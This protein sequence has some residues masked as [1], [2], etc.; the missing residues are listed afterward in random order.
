MPG[1]L[2]TLRPAAV[3]YTDPEIDLRAL[4]GHSFKIGALP[5]FFDV[6]LGQ[7]FRLGAPPN[8][9]RADF[10]LGVRPLDP[11]LVLV[12]SFNVISEG[13]GSVSNPD[14]AYH[15]LQLSVVYA[16]TPVL[17]LQLGGFETYMGHNALRERGAIMGVWAKF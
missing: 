5:A 14:Y 15:K 9:V 11:W 10:T 17:S 7:R 13:A 1:T 2:N 3:G 6:Q 16:V 4:L 8:E 12:Q